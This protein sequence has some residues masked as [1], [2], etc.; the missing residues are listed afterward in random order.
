MQHSLPYRV[1]GPVEVAHDGRPVDLGGPK[2]RLV[3][4]VLLLEAGRVVSI[5]RLAHLL[6]GEDPPSTAVATIQAYISKLRRALRTEASEASPI[7]RS[8][9]GYVLTVPDQQID[10][11]HFLAGT[12]AARE[13]IRLRDWRA[14]IAAAQQALAW[15]RGEPFGEF[16][17]EH[18][19]QTEAAALR[20]R[21]NECT[22]HLI[23]A[24]LGANRIAE[25][26]TQAGALA[27]AAPLSERACRL[28]MLVL[29][30]A[31]RSG[32]ALAAYR[33]FAGV[34][35][36][37]LGLEPGPA[38]RDVQAAI[39]RQDADLQEWPNP[40][41]LTTF[42]D[43][44]VGR[45]HEL[46]ALDEAL[47]ATL[48]GGSAWLLLSG[49]AGIGKSRLAE[50]AM[51]QARAAGVQTVRMSCPEDEG[52]PPWWPVRALL[53]SLGADV[54]AIFA[55]PRDLEAD[56][57][58][59]AIADRVQTELNELSRTQPLLIVVD[60]VQW[61]DSA[62]LRFLTNLTTTAGLNGFAVILTARDG[63]FR[64]DVQRLLAATGRRA[65]ARQLALPALTPEQV[66]ALV[67]H[68]SG[69]DLTP[70]QARL[71]TERTGGN[72]FFVSEYA[73]LPAS[74]RAAGQVPA[75]VRAVLNRRLSTT[76]PTVLNLL[77][78]AAIM[79]DQ[80]D[81]DLLGAVTHEPVDRLADALDTALD[82]GMIIVSPSTGN[83]VFAHG[84]LREEVLLGIPPVRRQQLH[85]RVADALTDAPD[86]RS[87]RA[88]HLVAALPFLPPAPVYEA[89]RA[90]ALD[91]ETRWDSDSASHWW[92][93]ARQVFAR[94]PIHPGSDDARD[95]LVEAQVEALARAGR[96]QQVLD[97]V[98]E[99][100]L[101]AGR[102]GRVR[103]LGRLAGGLLRTAG[104][105]PWVGYTSDPGPLITRLASVEP[106]VRADPSAQARVLAAMA[107]GSCYDPDESRRE[108]LSARAIACAEASGDNDALADA[109]LA[110]AVVFCGVITRVEE[111]RDLLLRLG[112]VPHAQARID[113]VLSH[114]MLSWVEMTLG[115]VD[116]AEEH[117][118]LGVGGC[119]LLRLPVART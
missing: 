71:L 101:V 1:L 25:A 8:A 14:G 86:H 18:W 112:Q 93:A 115:D 76:D 45:T 73:R 47:E 56:A 6:W 24:L 68:V 63:Q 113:E 17:D 46:L 100:L 81:V 15:W 44:F 84:L 31:G 107:V 7:T 43:G 50:E 117:R 119:D 59:F 110:R 95:H 78:H 38:L 90:A 21:R 2:Q 9:Q 23:T 72:P 30:R 27:G 36:E 85:A 48:A 57:A 55:R 61:A 52:L 53:R 99:A 41:E 106:L 89:C 49:P 83:Y 19:V 32:E 94:L 60:D 67:E 64:P 75:G 12:D 37:E 51:T 42:R 116:A 11:H 114:N 28:R 104:G 22:E 26:L 69:E 118:R 65:G 80:I 40:Q 33:T 35:D 79:G 82:A 92:G 54:D 77:R 39:L 3:L 5:D 13:A 29:H 74:D 109:L 111:V 70:E 108:D 88:G 20:E 16:T 10:T 34:L 105:W 97:V 91:A 96:D 66:A 87:R 58:R 102:E 98:D 62:S 103:S 4:T